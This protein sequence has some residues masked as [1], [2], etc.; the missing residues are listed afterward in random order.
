MKIEILEGTIEEVVELSKKIPE[1][2]NPHEKKEYQKRMTNRKH[3]ILIAYVNGEAAGF[4]VGYEKYSDGSFYSWMGGVLPVY[5][6]EG[7]ARVL[8]EYQENW[9]KGEGYTSI[10]FKTR[11]SHQKMLLFAIS[12]GFQIIEVIPREQI[13]EYRILLERILE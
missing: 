1:L 8:A 10:R 2:V 12:R 5:R 13:S 11:N 7:I 9:A 3:L 4:K 6:R